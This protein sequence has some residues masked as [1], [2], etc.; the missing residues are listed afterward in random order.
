MFAYIYQKERREKITFY[1]MSTASVLVLG[2]IAI[3]D[4]NSVAVLEAFG[5]LD[6]G[7]LHFSTVCAPWH[8]K[9]LLNIQYK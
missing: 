1:F 5:Q 6:P 3:G 4:A 9:S 7:R 2:A 8:K